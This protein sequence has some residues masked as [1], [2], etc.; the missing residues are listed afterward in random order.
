MAALAIDAAT[1]A[2]YLTSKPFLIPPGKMMLVIENNT[3]Q[4]FKAT[5]STVGYRVYS[6][7]IQ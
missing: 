2:R 6:E 3:G 4:A 1:T 7:E 5:D